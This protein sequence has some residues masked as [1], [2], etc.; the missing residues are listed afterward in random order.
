MTLDTLDPGIMLW[1]NRKGINN[2]EDILKIE[3]AAGSLTWGL[4][5]VLYAMPRR[6]RSQ[7]RREQGKM[8]R[9]N[10]TFDHTALEKAKILVHDLVG[11]LV[12]S[13]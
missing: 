3:E 8:N 5:M 9:A 10:M 13:I 11:W 12:G 2:R 1:L 4:L 7:S 6:G